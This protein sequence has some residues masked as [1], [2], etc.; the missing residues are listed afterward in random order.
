MAAD[1]VITTYR[2][3]GWDFGIGP[4]GEVILTVLYVDPKEEPKNQQELNAAV[5]TISFRMPDDSVGKL[6]EAALRVSG[7]NR[8]N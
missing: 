1:E 7:I 3:G 2:F 5:K 8:K 6:G 4:T